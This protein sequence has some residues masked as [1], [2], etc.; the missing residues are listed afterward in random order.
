MTRILGAWIFASALAATSAIS[1]FPYQRALQPVGLAGQHYLVVDEAIFQ[2]ARRDLGDLRLFGRETAVPYKL[3]IESGGSVAAQKTVGILQPG[4]VAAKTQFLIDTSA[5]QE[6]DRI[7]LQLGAKNFVIHARIEGQDDLHGTQWALLGTTTVYDLTDEKL[8]HNST[9]QLPL[10]AYKYLRVT[11]DSSAIK[12]A[13]ILGATAGVTHEEKAVWRDVQGQFNQVQQGKDTILTISVPAHSPVERINVE[14]DPIQANFRRAVEFRDDREQ[15]YGQ[16]E[17]SRIHTLRTGQKVD[18]EQTAL[19]VCTSCAGTAEEA[20]GAEVLKIVIHNGD[21]P[22]LKITGAKFQQYEHRVYFDGGPGSQLA[23]FYGDE[24]LEP[25]QYDYAKLFQ[26]D[27]GAQAVALSGEEL[28]AAYSARP[29][30]R[31]WSERHP[32]LLWVAILAAVAV[33]GSLALRSLRAPARSTE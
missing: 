32:R 17:V 12:P 2:H 9:L 30:G 7:I 18:F 23:L 5:V 31:P 13:N 21:D 25:P 19:T 29:D 6:Y 26:K 24:K 33:L 3:V 4:I 22:P 10:S 28:N 16:S 8:G 15:I 14:V 11:F 20:A 27:A 1:Y